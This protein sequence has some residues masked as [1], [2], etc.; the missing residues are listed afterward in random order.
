MNPAPTR[1]TFPAAQAV[2]LDPMTGQMT[3]IDTILT[4]IT[5]SLARS[6]ATE[7]LP[8]IQ[9]DQTMQRVIGGAAGH[10]VYEDAKWAIW[11][12]VGA[13]ALG[14]GALIYIAVKK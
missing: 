5:T 7:I 13:L 3:G 1:Q 8:L 12:G 14:A 6:V 9:R 4:Q 11:T 10:A 2:G